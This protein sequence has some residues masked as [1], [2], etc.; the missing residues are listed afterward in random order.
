MGSVAT[1]LWSQTRSCAG[2]LVRHLDGASWVLE[3]SGEADIATVGLLREELAHMAT[4]SREDVVVD[5]SAL[6]FCDVAS[7]DLL[8]TA[9]GT[10]LVT[11]SGATGPVQRV[12]DLVDAL[13]MHGLPACLPG[14]VTLSV[15]R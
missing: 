6:T 7:A 3:L 12:F 1:P 4:M 15:S 9:C 8:L 5:V 13:Q 14:G 11:L 10:S 2:L